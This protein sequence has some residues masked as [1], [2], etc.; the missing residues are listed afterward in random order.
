MRQKSGQQIAEIHYHTFKDYIETKNK[1]KGFPIRNGRL[2]RTQMSKDNG[3]DRAV[4]AQNPKVKELLEKLEKSEFPEET[5][6]LCRDDFY[7]RKLEKDLESTR[8]RLI[9]AQ[10]KNRELERQLEQYS[11]FE[12]HMI[13]TGRKISHKFEDTYS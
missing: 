7:I 9:E 8:Q 11:F 1:G 3:F 6:P 4:F 5:V 13:Q 2:N 12:E 10:A